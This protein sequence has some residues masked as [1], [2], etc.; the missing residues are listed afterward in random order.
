MQAR[1]V[2]NVGGQVHL[3]ASGSHS[4]GDVLAPSAVDGVNVGVVLGSS[5]IVAGDKFA[6]A[7]KGV[8]AFASASDTTFTKGSIPDWNDSTNLAVASG[9]FPLGGAILAKTSGQTEVLV[10]VN[11]FGD[12]AGS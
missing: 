6:V 7:T 9:T 8:F 11:E 4:P 12:Q 1:S 5:P 2:Y 3:V 10:H